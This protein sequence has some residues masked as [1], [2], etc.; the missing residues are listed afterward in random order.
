MPPAN[1]WEI[2]ALYPSPGG[3][4]G[5][6]KQPVIGGL[7]Y[8]QQATGTDLFSIHPFSELSGVFSN[9]CGHWFNSPMVQREYDY[10]TSSSVALIL[11]PLCGAVIYTLEPFESALNT[12][13]QPWLVA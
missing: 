8:P 4:G 11:C 6:W 13:E 7:V 9:F 3:Q 1:S 2:G 12:V 10:T 5:F